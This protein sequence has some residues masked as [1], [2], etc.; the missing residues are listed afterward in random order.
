MGKSFKTLLDIKVY[1]LT[2]KDIG[3]IKKQLSYANRFNDK[4]LPDYCI[5]QDNGKVT[6]SDYYFQFVETGEEKFLLF[7]VSTI[8]ELLK[9]EISGAGV[10]SILKDIDLRPFFKELEILGKDDILKYKLSPSQYLIIGIE[11]HECGSWE[12]PEWEALY[13]VDGVLTNN[14][15]LIELATAQ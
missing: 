11:Y 13:S 14:L 6:D 5:R 12:Y 2:G 7:N 1:E 9:E 8:D 3:E 15:K 4:F 10:D